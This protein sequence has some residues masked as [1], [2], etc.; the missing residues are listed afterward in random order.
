VR[1]TKRA[2]SEL[3][4]RTRL[5]DA[6]T[7][8]FSERGFRRVT[9]RQICRAARANVAAVNYHFGDKMGLYREVL[10]RATDVMQAT[11]EAARTAGANKPPEE[12]L[13]TFIA[14]FLERLQGTAES[15]ADERERHLRHTWLHRL[16]EI[17]IADPTPALD[18][19]VDR[20]VRPRIDYVSG[21]IAEILKC[22]PTD[23]RVLRCVGSIQSQC[24]MARPNPI[25]ARLM[26]SGSGAEAI[27]GL[28]DH[29]TAFSL[30]GIR[31][32]RSQAVDEPSRTSER[33]RRPPVRRSRR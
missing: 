29:I 18:T 17:E 28:T 19:I 16:I 4:T 1:E 6:A 10:Q 22:S 2:T 27:Q 24:L 23:P 33:P 32:V 30:A 12:R 3:R 31:A 8:L 21:I 11:T 7:R 15:L 13:R 9:V 14:V 25:A 26:A 5:V 20:G